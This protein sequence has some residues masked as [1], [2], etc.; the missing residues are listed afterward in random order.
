MDAATT[1]RW[2]DQIADDRDLPP[3]SMRVAVILRRYVNGRSGTAWPSHPT[4]I[5]VTGLSRSGLRKA[6]RGLEDHGHLAVSAHHGRGGTNSYRPL[7]AEKNDYACDPL[8]EEKDHGRDPISNENDHNRDPIIGEKGH[9]RNPERVTP[10]R[11]KGHRFA[12]ERVTGVTPEPLEDNPSKNSSNEPNTA[13]LSAD[14][15]KSSTSAS[16]TKDGIDA[17]FSDF[18]AAYPRKKDRGAARRAFATALKKTD[19][20]TL[21]RGAQRYASATIQT[22]PRFI[23]HP[24]SWL[25]AEAWLDDPEPARSVTLDADGNEVA[26]STGANSTRRFKTVSEQIEENFQKVM[27]GE[28]VMPC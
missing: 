1:F 17:A 22:E 12:Q 6:L 18:Y 28:I 10:V 25:N 5:E 4:L 21:I 3:V 23:K 13:R 14:S 20:A 24:S 15:N 27:N 26:G 16:D 11:K 19:A 8:S 7:I 9:T 2:L